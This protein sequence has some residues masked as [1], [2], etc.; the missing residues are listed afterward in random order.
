MGDWCRICFH[1]LQLLGAATLQQFPLPSCGPSNV[2]SS[3]SDDIC[4]IYI[5]LMF[6]AYAFSKILTNQG[7]VAFPRGHNHS[8]LPSGLCACVSLSI[9][10]YNPVILLP[11]GPPGPGTATALLIW[12]HFA[13]F[14]TICLSPSLDRYPVLQGQ[15]L[16]TAPRGTHRVRPTPTGTLDFMLGTAPAVKRMGKNWGRLDWV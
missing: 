13:T 8:P 12:L 1:C 2:A 4:E 3:Y 16:G 6:L 9:Y 14:L 11:L 5:S 15:S 7:E 10:V